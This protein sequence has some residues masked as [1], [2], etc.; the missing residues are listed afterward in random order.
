MKTQNLITWGLLVVIIYEL[1]K[2]A[3]CS[4]GTGGAGGAGGAG[5]G[6]CFPAGGGK[7]AN[8]YFPW[9]SKLGATINNEQKAAAQ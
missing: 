2:G 5:G 9:I 6:G 1:S 3:D 7:S 4:C 8:G